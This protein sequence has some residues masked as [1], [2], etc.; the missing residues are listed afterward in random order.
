[1][2]VSV[3]KFISIFIL[4]IGCTLVLDGQ[5]SGSKKL[6]KDQQLVL[7]NK[8]IQQESGLQP[9]GSLSIINT[10]T[11]LENGVTY[12]YFQQV[13]KGFE[14]YKAIGNMAYRDG[15]QILKKSRLQYNEDIFLNPKSSI[16]PDQAVHLIR[17]HL[18]LPV[19]KSS[20]QIEKLSQDS[21]IVPQMTSVHGQTELKKV[22]G[23]NKEGDYSPSW[24]ININPSTSSDQWEIIVDATDGA[25]LSESNSTLYC[26][27]KTEGQ[28]CQED[29]KRSQASHAVKEQ[30]AKPR[31]T[32]NQFSQVPDGSRYNVYAQPLESPNQGDRTIVVE[33]ANVNASPFGWHDINGVTGPEFDILR[34]NNVHAY[35]DIDA[36]NEAP[37][38][39]PVGQDLVFDF[40]IFETSNPETNID[41][42]VTNLFYWNN[43]L[44]DWSYI[45][46]FTE[47]AGNFQA[48]NYG[49]G[50]EQDDHVLA[51]TLDGSDTNNA[52]FSAPRDGANG[53]ME[54][55]KWNLVGEQFEVLSPAA[56]SGNY[57]TGSANFGPNLTSPVTGTLVYAEDSA[58]DIRDVCDPI[59][60]GSALE[61]NIAIVDR[62]ICDFSFKVFAVQEAGAIGCIVCNNLSDAP[63]ITM[64]AGDSANLVT[65]PSLFFTR[66][67]CQ[68]LKDALG[69]G[70]VGRF[71]E[72]QELSSSFD[73]GIVAHEYAHGITL[74]LTG[75]AGTSACLNNDEQMGEGW[76][77][78]FGLVLTQQE[79]DNGSE[80][81]GI[82][83]YVLSQPRE[84]RGI[85][86]YQYST[87]MAI[88]PQVHSHI[89]F[90]ARPHDVGEIWTAALWDMYWAFI[91]QDGYDP[92]WTDPTA[93]N[94]RAIQIVMDGLKLQECDP[95]LIEGRDAI[96]EADR[97]NNFGG[98]ECLIWSAFARR[99]LG[100][101]AQSND[102]DF[103]GDNVDGFE[104][105]LSCSGD[106]IIQKEMTPFFNPGEDILVQLKISNY[107][108][109]LTDLRVIADIP[110]GT[111]F[112]SSDTDVLVELGGDN[113]NFDIGSLDV[114]EEV[115]INYVLGT[116]DIPFSTFELFDDL[117]G[118][119]AFENTTTNDFL[120]GWGLLTG[121]DGSGSMSLRVFQDT[122]GGE[123]YATRS[124]RIQISPANRLLKFNHRYETDLGIDGGRVEVSTDGGAS[125]TAID[126]ERYLVNGPPDEI[127]NCFNNCP[128]PDF[129][130]RNVTDAFTGNGSQQTT[131]IDLEDYMGQTIMIRFNFI[132]LLFEDRLGGLAWSVD[133]FELY[134]RRTVAGQACVMSGNEALVCDDDFSIINS[135][136]LI[137]P[138]TEIVTDAFSLSVHPNPADQVVFLQLENQ[139]RLKGDMRIVGIDG[140]VVVQ[141]PIELT[142]GRH[143]LRENVTSLLPGL[144]LIEISD[145]DERY[146][147]AF[148]KQ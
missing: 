85:R 136:A 17:S 104:V 82:G 126:E 108:E 148:I 61:G 50:G 42:D 96:L 71:N 32:Q 60:N 138:V 141:K 78:F 29:H 13:Y 23:K 131:I 143:E 134:E 89:R 67:D 70:V 81:R 59:V 92:T 127:S 128:F 93:G 40:P 47:A 116:E 22:W 95:S 120:A 9:I 115:I 124:E 19:L 147:V 58:G 75:G 107:K 4:S 130:Y 52:T 94:L 86:R 123:S 98:N 99:G 114:G 64:S 41:A 10:H 72:A 16:E 34:G 63:L 121:S 88:N 146:T 3:I 48:N 90:S 117:D 137:D 97:L 27:F 26:T 133:D 101:D 105:P 102:S 5:T 46:G 112:K 129:F 100:V 69:Q 12:V 6:N 35:Q 55:F 11:N 7:I 74:R 145:Q 24:M 33:P 122:L 110:D 125:W 36:D 57:E 1:M 54:M 111:S 76:S 20:Y 103:R 91:E 113:M 56:L 73:N 49:K 142:A 83:T 39:Q 132:S 84:G 66:E 38:D 140:R 2:N 118:E 51:E 21:Y 144:Y 25:I 109:S 15:L 68:L 18:H 106:L 45:F 53:T 87:D 62:G 37:D 44:H 135:N 77:D 119:M 31:N 28:E 80:S 139:K 65:I 79:E 30:V 8:S 14:V 43:F